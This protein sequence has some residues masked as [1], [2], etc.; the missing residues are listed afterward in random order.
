[1]ALYVCMKDRITF[2]LLGLGLA[3]FPSLKYS[4]LILDGPDA[5]FYGFP[6][7]WNS[8]SLAFSLAKDV[9]VIPLLID[10]AFF[11]GAVALIRRWL[12][13]WL[14]NVSLG[15]RRSVAAV[16]WIY[17][18]CS[19]AMMLVTVAVVDMSVHPW[20]AWPVAEIRSIRMGPN[21]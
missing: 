17:G 8:R 5:E 13:P 11:V 4:V 9:Y 14:N 7:P 6:L 3:Y 1:M 12:L 18:G 15:V 21:L 20:Y 2:A 19:L 10:I 16:T